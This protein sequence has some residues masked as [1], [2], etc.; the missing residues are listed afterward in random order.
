MAV[1]QIYGTYLIVHAVFGNHGVRGFGYLAYI[2]GGAGG[3]LVHFKLLGN[4]AA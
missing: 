2:A 4:A 3:Y 1:A